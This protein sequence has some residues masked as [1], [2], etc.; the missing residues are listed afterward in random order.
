MSTDRP[1]TYPPLLEVRAGLAER[2]CHRSG[3][4]LT[5]IQVRLMPN[6][7]LL[8]YATIILNNV[9]RIADI[10]IIDGDRRLFVAMPS[11]KDKDGNYRDIAHPIDPD[12]RNY[13]EHRILDV[14]YRVEAEARGA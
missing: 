6:G 5:G 12:F 10:R 7:R 8:G 2:Q 4:E 1:S 9:F 13:L 11:R 3:L 14:Y